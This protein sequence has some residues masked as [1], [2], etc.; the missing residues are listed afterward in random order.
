MNAIGIRLVGFLGAA[1]LS[2][3]CGGQSADRSGSQAACANDLPEGFSCERALS[4]EQSECAGNATGV[5]LTPNVHWT[6]DGKALHVEDTRFR[7]NQS[8]CAYLD[9]S[10]AEAKV[11]LQPC[12][13]KPNTV[14]RCDC[15]YSFDVPVALPATTSSISVELRT[16]AYASEPTSQAAGSVRVGA[17]AKLCDGSSAL[18][19]AATSGGGNLGGLPPYLAEVGWSLLLIDGQCRYYAMTA[20]DHEIRTGVLNDTDAQSF[21]DELSLGAWPAPSPTDT[22]FDASTQTYAFGADRT[23]VTCESTP[24]SQASDAWLE[25]LYQAGTP[26]NGPV[27]SWLTEPSNEHWPAS[28]PDLALPYPFAELQSAVSDP[29]GVSHVAVISNAAD[30]AALRALR[31][32]YQTKPASAFVAPYSIP[33]VFSPSETESK[34][35]DL[36]LRDT[37]PFEVDGA[38][39]IDAFIQ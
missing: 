9:A 38:L 2:I 13:M 10:S 31:A 26:V 20:P 25:R 17:G 29:F 28:N 1:L 35:Y 22:C 30:A 37:L 33:V 12:E 4:I 19:F 6:T 5:S 3:G 15:E 24:L 27:R 7:C 16:D 39:A 23:S 14:A 36:T 34:Y 32:E 8:V 18:R 21:S 11:L